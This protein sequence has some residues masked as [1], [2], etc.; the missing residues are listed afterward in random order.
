[1]HD[2]NRL[3]VIALIKCTESFWSMRVNDLCHLFISVGEPYRVN[4]LLKMRDVVVLLLLF[5]S[6]ELI[7]LI[8]ISTRIFYKARSKM[9]NSLAILFQVFVRHFQRKTNYLLF[10]HLTVRRQNFIFC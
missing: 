1:M 6:F 9:F 2:V 8:E 10:I 5:F 7:L 3:L 4:V